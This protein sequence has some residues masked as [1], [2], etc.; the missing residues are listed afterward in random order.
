[1]LAFDRFGSG[2]P[3]VLLHGTN[4]SRDVWARLMPLLA[5][6]RDVIAFDLPA[7]GTSPPTSFTPPHFATELATAFAEL[8][9]GAPAVVG[10]SVGG[11]VALELAR[12][13]HAAAVLALAP[14]GLWRR[15]S[16]LLT[17]LGLRVNWRLGQVLGRAAELPLRSSLGR[18]VSLS[19]ISARPS[20]VSYEAAVAAALNATAAPAAR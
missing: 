13:E 14:A 17:D 18:R 16:P 6:Q 15:R 11:W 4:S 7:H 1:M 9:L 8:G 20:A 19:S 5:A 12:R 3:L 10:H 2:E